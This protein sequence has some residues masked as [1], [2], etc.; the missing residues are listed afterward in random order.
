MKLWT[1]IRTAYNRWNPDYQCGSV[2]APADP[3][4]GNYGFFAGYLWRQWRAERRGHQG[5]T[6][7]SVP[8]AELLPAEGVLREDPNEDITDLELAADIARADAAKRGNDT[9][10]DVLGGIDP[11]IHKANKPIFT[12]MLADFDAA[13]NAIVDRFNNEPQAPRRVLIAAEHTQEIDITAIRDFARK[14][15][16]A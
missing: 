9:S 16:A 1:Y 14:A 5:V 15:L 13:F 10:D 11:E 7:K 8:L 2:N 4:I 12:Q 6:A 3:N